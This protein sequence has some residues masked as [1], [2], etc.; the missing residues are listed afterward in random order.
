M[1]IFSKSL[2]A[3]AIAL[4]LLSPSWAAVTST[5]VFT[6][7]P[8]LALVQITNAMG[9]TAQTLY[10]CGANGSKLIA[11]IAAT[12]DTGANTLQI[13]LSRSATTYLLTTQ[14]VALSSG[15]VAGVPNVNLLTATAVPGLPYDSDGNPFIY[16]QSGDT[17]LAGA[18]V[19]IGA[20]KL[21]SVWAVVAD[22]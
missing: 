17:I 6:Q 8:K 14:T 4:A 16:C 5:P 21:L 3:L 12:T 11:I 13:S 10:T 20:A 22:F 2:A 7:T 15:N 1:K 19:A 18:T 9:T